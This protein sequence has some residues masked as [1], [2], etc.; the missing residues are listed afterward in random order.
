M[1]KL[2]SAFIAL[3]LL[4]PAAHVGAQ[5]PNLTAT[6]GS[7]TFTV[8]TVTNN[9]TYSPRNVLAIWIKNSQGNFVISRKVMAAARKQHLVKWNASSGNNSVN[10][11]TG[12]TLP[13][14]QT[15]TISWDCRDLAGNL[16][17][18]GVYQVWVEFTERNSAGGGAAGPSFSISF[19]KGIDPVSLNIPDESY[20]KN[21]TLSY[22]PQ[23]VGVDYQLGSEYGISLFP[24]P[25]S[26]EVNINFVLIEQSYVNVSV[27]S[28]DTKRVAELVDG[29][30]ASG[31]Q[32]IKWDGLTLPGEKVQPGIYTVRILINNKIYSR[33]VVITR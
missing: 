22:S 21:M 6:D 16:V 30:F 18:D 17:E 31:N 8:Q 23:G 32:H 20:F 27:Y 12:A 7:M 14:H 11:I 10:A 26:S 33:K 2:L 13:N 25:S 4:L 29:L 1:K 5:A 15:H 3:L 19:T 24:N 28:A 9:A